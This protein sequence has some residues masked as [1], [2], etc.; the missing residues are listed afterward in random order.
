MKALSRGEETML[1][2]SELA[3]ARQDHASYWSDCFTWN[4]IVNAY[5]AAVP[6]GYPRV[7]GWRNNKR[8]LHMTVG[9]L[10]RG[11]IAGGSIRKV[12]KG[13]YRF[14]NSSRTL[15]WRCVTPLYARNF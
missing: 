4:D 3:Y 8:R 6:V 15:G 7:S 9:R 14:N 11:Q 1:I 5:D 2:V 12:E 10:L 13:L